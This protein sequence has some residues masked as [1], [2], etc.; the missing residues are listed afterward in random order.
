[1]VVHMFQHERRGMLVAQQLCLKRSINA[2]DLQ[3]VGFESFAQ[4]QN[5]LGFT[6]SIIISPPAIRMWK[7]RNSFF[8]S[9]D[10]A[11]YIAA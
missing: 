11:P 5:N 1:M 7:F 6:Q 2:I 4:R 3:F 10:S 9:A 8:S